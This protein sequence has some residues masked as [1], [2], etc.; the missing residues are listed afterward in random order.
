M[1]VTSFDFDTRFAAAFAAWR[2]GELS[3]AE[4]QARL[5]LAQSPNHPA[6]LSLLG[7][8]QTAEG[9]HGEAVA[10]FDLLCRLQPDQSQHWVDLGNAYRG[11]GQHD[12]ALKALTKAAE[13]GNR[14][15]PFLFNLGLTHFAR[16]DFE[17]ARSIFEEAVRVAPDDTEIRYRYILS[18]YECLRFDLALA[19]IEDWALPPDAPAE[20]IAGIGQMLLNMGEY[21]RAEEMIGKVPEAA[22]D[23][24]RT[25][26]IL[27]Q[28]LERTNQ[29]EKAAEL[30]ALLQA[31]RRSEMLGAE[32]LHVS[33]K[34]AS[35]QGN[36]AL[37]LELNR[38]VLADY[39][40]PQD[41]HFVL[42]PIAASL[43]KLGRYDEAIRTLHEAHQ[44]QAAYIRRSRPATALRGAPQMEITNFPCDAADIATW[45]HTGAPSKADSPVFVVAFPRSGTT[46]LEL[47]LDAHPLLQSMDEQPFVQNMIEDV[48]AYDKIYPER[49]GLLTREQLDSIRA[50][51]WERVAKKVQV[52][53][54]Q[55]LVDKNPLNMLRLAV[56]RRIF[57]NAT[58]LLA[59]RHPCDVILSCFMQ[60]FR[61][62]DFSMLC[63]ELPTLTL[64]YRKTFD[65]WYEQVALLGADPA[66]PL[67]IR[68]VRYETFVAAFEKETRSIAAFLDLPWDD[69]MLAPGARAQAKGYIS[70]PSYSQVIKPV[71]QKAVGRWQAYRQYLEPALPILQP[72]FERWHYS[73]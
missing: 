61:A 17:A 34:I 65:F 35:R 4:R 50:R 45:D 52:A 72:Y 1:S 25:R 5:L 23:D 38:R 8:I 33:A 39:R 12:D 56:I 48:R 9:R 62:P 43:D 47:T 54:G 36:D 64:G 18:C 24:P 6:L 46:L 44:S 31:D 59:V 73:A 67:N 57:P 13:L 37:A 70:T 19:A 14:S 7:T 2:R 42:F 26:A 22:R 40:E 58:I 71:N 16:G 53:P 51:Y 55:R 21:A 41:R 66:V 32:L 69:A 20:N 29:V 68:E 15:T 11:T 28:V 30:L 60:H 3:D 63:S 10:A 49:L 27:V